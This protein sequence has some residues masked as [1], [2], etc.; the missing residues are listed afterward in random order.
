MQLNHNLLLPQ[1]ANAN[2]PAMQPNKRRI[3]VVDNDPVSAEV[4]PLCQPLLEC[5][6]QVI[7]VINPR[8]ALAQ[9]RFASDS[10]EDS[11]PFLVI[12]DLFLSDMDGLDFVQEIRRLQKS[13]NQITRILLVAT[14]ESNPTFE[15]AV[16][17][18]GA[19]D[20]IVKP[21]RSSDLLL[22]V[23]RL[24]RGLPGV[25]LEQLE[26]V[27]LETRRGKEIEAEPI[28]EED[29]PFRALRRNDFDFD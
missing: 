16:L 19:D 2:N 11:I 10:Q 29:S 6:Y 4:H 8:E 15:Q 1:N 5:G 17:N 28:Q 24:M 18:M 21:V 12:C 20:F 14:I 27:R 26:T 3:L 23:R 25:I 13:T 9:L 7:H 22:R